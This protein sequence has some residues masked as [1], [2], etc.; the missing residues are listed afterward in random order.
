MAF[1]A[2]LIRELLFGVRAVLFLDGD[3]LQRKLLGGV[4]PAAS[5]PAASV[6][7]ALPVVVF[8]VLAGCLV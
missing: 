7:A 3:L 6:F 2:L 8:T 5:P 1:C 4:S